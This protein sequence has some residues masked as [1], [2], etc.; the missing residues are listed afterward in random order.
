MNRGEFKSP[1]VCSSILVFF[2]NR[3]RKN[4]VDKIRGNF[5]WKILLGWCLILTFVAPLLGK[6]SKGNAWQLMR[7]PPGNLLGR[8]A[9]ATGTGGFSSYLFF[10]GG[11]SGVSNNSSWKWKMLQ[12]FCHVFL[13]RDSFSA[14]KNLQ[15]AL[16]NVYQHSPNSPVTSLFQLSSWRF[17]VNV[18]FLGDGDFSWP[19]QRL[20]WWLPTKG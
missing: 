7:W 1:C 3:A 13:E 11:G 14:S 17:W 10:L 12:G 9:S 18:T 15:L 8:S 19:L 20:E 5:H 6:F 16:Q 4:F 2:L